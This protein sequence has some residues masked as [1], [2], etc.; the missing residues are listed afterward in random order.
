MVV[1]AGPPCWF[2]SLARHQG[3]LLALPAG[4][5]MT[6]ADHLWVRG[7][8]RVIGGSLCG[9]LWL[10]VWLPSGLLLGCPLP[11]NDFILNYKGVMWAP[12]VVSGHLGECLCASVGLCGLG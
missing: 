9:C 12:V 4:P 5:L 10:S 8:L 6:P 2:P 7:I 11:W 1:P 3:L